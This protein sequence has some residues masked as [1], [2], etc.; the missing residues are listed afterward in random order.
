MRIRGRWKLIAMVGIGLVGAWAY[1][2]AAIRRAEATYPPEGRRVPCGCGEELVHV[3]ESGD[4]PPLILVHGADG[5]WLDFPR[6]LVDRLSSTHRVIRPDR[7]GHG[8]SDGVPAGAPPLRA[9]AER[10]R[11][12]VAALG[13]ARPIVIGH[14]YGCALALRWALD[15]PDEL[16]GLLLLAPAAYDIWPAWT[17]RLMAVPATTAGRAAAEILVPLGVPV[18]HVANARAFWPQRMPREYRRQARAMFLRP[19]QF[20]ALAEEYRWV[21]ED[22]GAMRDRYGT[23]RLPVE[24]VAGDADLVTP[25][26]REA[27]RLAAEIPRASL[28]I[29]PGVGHQL[30]WSHDD[31][32]FAALERLEARVSSAS[33]GVGQGREAR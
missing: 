27:V 18:L 33:L 21:S 24:I 30:H 5:V 20:A 17:P 13:V 25:T 4:G 22:L 7:P 9:Q 10:L 1:G 2:R 29:L 19:T 23:L 6:R 3:T 11:A 32:M 14:S 26:D 31:A 15:H 16:D 12:A 28:A 8:Y